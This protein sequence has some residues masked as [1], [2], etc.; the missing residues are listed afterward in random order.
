MIGPFNV[1][2]LFTLLNILD[3]LI[4]LKNLAFVVVVF[5]NCV[6]QGVGTLV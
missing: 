4:A 5:Y 6:V 1:E 3:D 2:I